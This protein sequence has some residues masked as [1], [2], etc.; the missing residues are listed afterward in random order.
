MV[1]KKLRGKNSTV[2]NAKHLIYNSLENG[3]CFIANSYHAN[4]KGFKFFGKCENKI[5]QMG[6]TINGNNGK[7][8]L[9]VRLPNKNGEI[10]LI[11]NGN[12]ISNIESN[13]GDFLVTKSGQYRVEVYLNGMAWIF[14]NHIR[15]E[16]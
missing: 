4:A 13:E 3:C 8:T 15:I 7:I 1:D 2:E 11:H 16:N 9:K 5:Y 6:D 14:S 12:I 10:R